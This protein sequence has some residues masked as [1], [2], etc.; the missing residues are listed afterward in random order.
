LGLI[1]PLIGFTKKGEGMNAGSPWPA[2]NMPG[3][4]PLAPI[5]CPKH[6]NMDQNMPW[7]AKVKKKLQRADWGKKTATAI[8]YCLH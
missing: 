5:I 3:Y 7:N 6:Y 8:L 4:I 1:W 2:C